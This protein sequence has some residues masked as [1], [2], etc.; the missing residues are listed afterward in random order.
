MT[1]ERVGVGAVKI[2]H[3]PAVASEG[4]QLADAR[5]PG[6]LTHA[7]ATPVARSPSHPEASAI[8]VSGSEQGMAAKRSSRIVLNQSIVSWRC[9]GES[10]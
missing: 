1:A 8:S 6:K 5:S 7:A 9:A 4:S 10:E 2:S 3:A